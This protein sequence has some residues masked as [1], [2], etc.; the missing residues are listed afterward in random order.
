LATL[1][2]LQKSKAKKTKK[3][4]GSG[5]DDDMFA[6]DSFDEIVERKPRGG[7]ARKPVSYAMDLDSDESS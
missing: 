2:L 6:E 5:S 7:R 1:S 4:K 3:K